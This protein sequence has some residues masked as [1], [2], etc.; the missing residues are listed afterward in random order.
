M[1]TGTTKHRPTNI[2]PTLFLENNKNR[3]IDLGKCKKYTRNGWEQHANKYQK[4]RYNMHKL[5]KLHTNKFKIGVTITKS[6]RTPTQ[7][8]Q[9][10]A[11][12][13]LVMALGLTKNQYAF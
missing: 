10:G 9:N 3:L 7:V 2:A 6:L 12:A 1:S 4:W 11:N 13:N 8:Q 5:Q